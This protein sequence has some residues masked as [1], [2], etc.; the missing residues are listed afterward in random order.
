M[1]GNP[2]STAPGRVVLATQTKR[3]I[4]P[5]YIVTSHIGVSPLIILTTF[6]LASLSCLTL[7]E[8]LRQYNHCRLCTAGTIST[9]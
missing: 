2:R 5:F 8:R 3:S 7:C 4:T 1:W 9:T 6:F